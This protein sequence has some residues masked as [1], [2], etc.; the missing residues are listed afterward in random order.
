MNN[1]MNILKRMMAFLLAMLLLTTMMG[2]D[3]SSLADSDLDM[4]TETI[5]DDG[6]AADVET[7]EGETADTATPEPEVTEEVTEPVE[8]EPEVTEPEVTDPEVT[9]EVTN[10]EE[11]NIDD[12]QNIDETEEIVP[13][14]EVPEE[15]AEE[16]CEHDW[17]AVS[18]D[19]GTHTWVCT[20]CEEKGETEDCE[21][22]EDGICIRCG[23]EQPAEEEECDHEWEYTSNDDGTHT[24]RCT[25][26]GVEEV[27]DCEFD[28]DWVCVHCKYEDMS[29][30]YQ[31]YSKTIHG[32]K[33]TVAGEMPRKSK[34]TIYT[35]SLKKVNDIVN[36]TIDEGTFE[37]YEAFD[38]TIYDRHGDKYQPKDDGNSVSV[39]FEGVSELADT[40]DEEIVA[41]RIEDDQE[42]V[43]EIPT[44]VAGEDVS[45][46]AEHFSTYVVGTISD[47]S[48]IELED[49]QNFA[50]VTTA[51][52][53]TTYTKP[54]KAT[55]V[56]YVS[57]ASETYSFT[58]TA[59]K[60]LSSTSLPTSGTKVATG[61]QDLTPDG[62]GYYTIEIDLTESVSGNS[63]VTKGN[64]YAIV[65]SSSTAVNLCYGSTYENSLSSQTYIKGNSSTSWNC[66]GTYNDAFYLSTSA[67]SDLGCKA[68]LELT[69]TISDSYKVASITTTS[70]PD[71]DDVYHYAVGNTDTLTAVLSD[72][73]IE[74]SITWESSDPLIAEVTSKGTMTATLKALKAGTVTI[75]ATYNGESKEITVNVVDVY[76]GGV[77]TLEGASAYSTSYTGSAIT[78]SVVLY[79]ASGTTV[80]TTSAAYPYMTS[81]C[82][83]NKDAGT[84]TVVVKYYP[85]VDAAYTYTR[86]FTINPIDITTTSS[87]DGNNAFAAANYKVTSGSV[88]S[89]TNV[90]S[91]SALAVTPVFNTDFTA[92]VSSLTGVTSSIVI[93]ADDSSCSGNFTGT[94]TV[95]S[96]DTDISNALTVSLSSNSRLLDC[97]YTGTAY[98]LTEVTDVGWSEVTFYNSNNKE[99][100]GVVTK[101]SATYKIYDY[102][103]GYSATD[104]AAKGAEVSDTKAGKKAIVFT[105]NSDSGYTGSIFTTFTIQQE[106]MSKVTIVWKNGN[107]FAHT[108]SAIEPVA[109]TDFVAYLGYESAINPGV[110]VSAADYNVTYQGDHINTSDSPRVKITGA[111]TNFD[112][113]T[114]TTS[115]YFIVPNYELDLVVRI[116]DSGT[117]YDGTYSNSY[118][119]GYSKYYD[120]NPT[121]VPNISVRLN[122]ALTYGTDY[123]YT[124]YDSYDA[125]AGT[126]TTLTEKVGTKYIVVTGLNNGTTDY[127]KYKPVVATYKVES[128]PLNNS[129]ITV[130]FGTNAS[131][132]T[133][134]GAAL[135][136]STATDASTAKVATALSNGVPTTWSTSTTTNAD[137]TIKYGN[138]YLIEGT[139][140]KINYGDDY[141][142]VGTVSP[143]ITGLGNYTGDLSGTYTYSITAASLSDGGTATAALAATEAFAY[144]GSDHTPSVKVTIGTTFTETFKYD[145]TTQSLTSTNFT[146]AYKDNRSPGTATITVTGKNNLTGSA[147]I[148]FTISSNKDAYSAIY[149]G[150]TNPAE[151]VSVAEEK[152]S[153]GNVTGYTR[154]YKCSSLVTYYTGSIYS[155]SVA[156]YGSDGTLLTRNTHYAASYKNAKAANTSTD[157]TSSSPYLKITGLDSYAGNNAI[158][159]FNIQP[160]EITE[161]MVSGIETSY[162]WNSSAPVTPSPVV[163]YKSALTVSTDYTVAYYD[164]YDAS[165]G[166]GT[167][168][169]TVAGTKYLVIKGTG[170][171]TGTVVIPY[172]VGTDISQGKVS[173][174]GAYYDAN[175]N[176]QGEDYACILG[177]I[178]TLEANPVSLMWRNSQAPKVLLYDKHN[179]KIYDADDNT[180][181]NVSI[182]SITSNLGLTG[183]KLYDAREAKGTG[184]S[185]LITMVVSGDTSKGFYGTAKICYYINP[186]PLGGQRVNAIATKEQHYTG[187]DIT[188]DPA[189]IFTYSYSDTKQVYTTVEAGHSMA[190]TSDDYTCEGNIGS[191]VGTNA[192]L[193]VTGVGNYSGDASLGFKIVEGYENVYL[194]TIATETLIATTD[195]ATNSYSLDDKTTFIYT[196]EEIKPNLVITDASNNKLVEN[197][198]YT[199]AYTNNVDPSTDGNTAVATYTITNTNFVTKTIT[200]TYTIKTNSI[201]NFDAELSDFVYDGTDITAG[202]VKSAIEAGTATLSLSSENKE[203]TY[204]SDY[205]ILTSAPSDLTDYVGS[206]D[207]PSTGEAYI[208]VKGNLPYSGYKKVT[209][210]IL[211]NLN[212]VYAD[213][214]IKDPYYELDANGKTTSDITPVISYRTTLDD[215][216]VYSGIISDT[217]SKC[218]ITRTRD[219]LPGPDANITITAK[220]GTELTGSKVNARYVS[221]AGVSSVVYFKADLSTY[222]G[223]TMT[224]GTVYEY[225]GESVSVT[226]SG[227]EDATEAVVG[228]LQGDYSVVYTKDY[229]NYTNGVDPIEVGTYYAV[230]VP[231]Q[232]SKYFIYG[233]TSENSFSFK[234]KYNL[235]SANT[236]VKFYSGA[237]EVNN[238][239]Y[240]GSAQ[241]VPAII[242][243]AYDAS[244]DSSDTLHNVQIYDYKTTNTMVTIDP[245]TATKMG[246]YS[247]VATPKDDD[248]VYGRLTSTFTISGVDINECDISIEQGPFS[249]TGSAIKPTVTI[250]HSGST[251][252][253]DT[254]Y[255]VTYSNNISAGTGKIII[256]GINAYSGVVDDITFTIEPVAIT[257]N[258]ITVD[259]ATY[260]GKNVEV[261][262]AITV[263]L[264][265]YVLTEGTDYTTP[266]YANNTY[267]RTDASVTISAGTSGNFTGTNIKK[268]FT[269]EKLDLTVADIT[270]SPSSVEWTGTEIDPYTKVTVKLG[271]VTL[272]SDKEDTTYDYKIVV[273][274]NGVESTL[275]NQGT[276][277]LRIDAGN[278]PNCANYKEISFEVTKRSLSNNYHYYYDKVST[279]YAGAT[280]DYE[281]TNKRY[282]TNYSTGLTVY[283]PDVVTIGGDNEPDILIVDKG[284]VDTS[285][286]TGYKHLK[287]DT[288]YTI[289]LSNNSGAGSAAW[290]K[291]GD[292]TTNATV[293]ST[294]P[295]I[296][297]TGIGNYM[298][299]I[300]LPYNIGQNLNTLDLTVTYT[301]TGSNISNPITYVESK[302]DE[303]EWYYEYNGQQLRPSVTV[304]N[305]TSQLKVNTDYTISYTDATGNDDTC[306]NAG[307]KYIVITGKGDYCGT[308]SKK[309]AIHRKAVNAKL[310]KTNTSDLVQGTVFTTENPMLATS[311]GTSAGTTMLTF[312]VTGTT[313]KRFT[314]ATAE[315]YLAK[316]YTDEDGNVTGIMS[317]EDADKFEGYYYAVYDGTTI[318]P[319]VTVKDNVL[320]TTISEDDINVEGAS[321]TVTS[322]T[323]TNGTVTSYVCSN[324]EVSFKG[325]EA[326]GG[327][328]GNYYVPSG[329]SSTFTIE[330]IVVQHDMSSDFD[331]SIAFD[332]TVDGLDGNNVNY[333][334]GKLITGTVTV[335]RNQLELVEDTDYT[336][337]Y[338]NNWLPG[339]ATVTITGKG[340]YKGTKTLKFYIWGNLD[341]TLTYYKDANDNYVQGNPLTQQYTG[342]GITYGEPRIYLGLPVLPGAYQTET[343][344][345]TAGTEYEAT[346]QPTS[347]DS[348]VSTGTVYYSG[349]SSAYWSGDKEIDYAVDFNTSDIKADNYD[350]S[351]EFTGYPIE[352]DFEINVSTATITGI[353]Y[354]RMDKNGSILEENTSDLTSI[355]PDDGYIEATIAY[356]IGDRTGS[357]TADYSITARN[358]STNNDKKDDRV[359]VICSSTYPRY[360]GMAVNPPF[361][362]YIQSKNLKTG[363]VQKYYDLTLYD[364]T[365]DSP[366]G[367]YDVDYGD[368]EYGDGEIKFT[369]KSDRLTGTLNKSYTIKLQSVA[370]LRITE[371]TGSTMTAEWVRDMYSDG[372]ALK[373]QKLDTSTNEYVDVMMTGVSGKTNTYT[374]TG[375]ASSTTYKVIA[376]AYAT[377]SDGTSIES[378]EEFV[379]ETTGVATSAIKVES[380]KA[381]KATVS[382]NTSGN[383]IAYYIY[384]ADDETSTGKLVAIIPA[385]TGKYTN[386]KLT[387][388]ATYYYHIDGYAVVDDELT[389]VNESE[390]VAVTV[391]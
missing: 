355:T 37:A 191:T 218:T 172:D 62:T 212:S 300:S 65:V 232:E 155:G 217:V 274:N 86:T 268:T 168:I 83:N 161:D 387:S 23:Y 372:T 95:S 118:V 384:R 255:T 377:T 299:T 170:N 64:S 233:K 63:Y 216:G 208:Y 133:F 354:N 215:P 175:N 159:Y 143:T 144:T 245:A 186:Q 240:T 120:G 352:P 224:S 101:S 121:S 286:T 171:Y 348:F 289:S 21:F 10:P 306:I 57:D 305:G 382:W 256:Q 61:S 119:T 301:P 54:L 90:N 336:V 3:F 153:S 40:P 241:D 2:D 98:S 142:N 147:V 80:G 353:T 55:F 31:E 96:S 182:Q 132:K 108:G 339:E 259:T 321:N 226:F 140:F 134:T 357:V 275:K 17:K 344:I 204:G 81:S 112:S 261:K 141:I 288:D 235:S 50:A 192:T 125:T 368:Y 373:L 281:S 351:Y 367:D 164:S 319:T 103:S 89:V 44:D 84:A 222:K 92:T 178:S 297:I 196:G 205:T 258:M 157:Y 177:E 359:V 326:I 146:V 246:T 36:E 264:G 380:K 93:N 13:E 189:F 214:S 358:L 99:V 267:A 315:T 179:T 220:S 8:T 115:A 85:T 343:Y 117:Y 135:T 247:I 43:T 243:A 41:Y 329:G 323:K 364:E 160:R 176:V 376:T 197:T 307:Y 1:S 260:A 188:V 322:F 345:L 219:T 79:S 150:G 29:L 167:N 122:G 237:V 231:T 180:V 87:T 200:F 38:I 308:L 320:G 28:E 126:G 106:S 365:A 290:N 30:E 137:L 244:A 253:K 124:V 68:S 295:T 302:K 138:T 66:S 97:Y 185:N 47:V 316:S 327:T 374:F 111:G 254:D 202:E 221:S 338:E 271:D 349:V 15:D 278:S 110:E 7:T 51:T 383:V 123:T 156:V 311:D 381:G 341:D 199:V 280:W 184:A 181:G 22:G 27:E 335:T 48:Y 378:E 317:T 292:E 77:S 67:N 391:K 154:Y 91:N 56:I 58:A 12:S 342:K 324:I 213:V 266:V 107:E 350:P 285:T 282:V 390:H 35:K 207:A 4:V 25:K 128:R 195:A 198:D 277:Q 230:I 283:I 331:V 238:I 104:Y 228:A 166:T 262:P 190:L 130:S 151:Y 158:V 250:T 24:K 73:S 328:G 139:D 263:K 234:I 291:D 242:Y 34:V 310:L 174:L 211:L 75:T 163:T 370:N 333:D 165:T 82:S 369:G 60:N 304:F 379:I 76:I 340:N 194:G 252:K 148:T 251:L 284:I 227:L 9:D 19:D 279:D 346:K 20:K 18:N 314:Q 59:Y 389:K 71:N 201:E 11:I 100:P 225:T 388:G 162:T 270:V 210:N 294:S 88:T 129:A 169:T 136:W 265:N 53:D 309:Y 6:A 206:N 249:Y 105:M 45:F 114:Y 102:V 5:Q 49:W 296:T 203:L 127:S 385:S 272:I 334:D 78:P 375:L 14:E 312:S 223:I 325:T 287:K 74:R 347:N 386:S 32:V 33:V 152:D 337:E 276:Y 69:D 70:T 145:S 366:S 183:D 209:F 94:V 303:V 187:S 109:G 236:K 273:L 52:S 332:D 72:S 330:Y 362:I 149:I 318:N 371:D 116:S 42:T 313:L 16:E 363:A 298:D 361:E 239:P 39:T 193:T 360:T 26:C 229:N 293:A 46:D 248:L 173:I 131:E 269:I 257:P 356:S 113:S